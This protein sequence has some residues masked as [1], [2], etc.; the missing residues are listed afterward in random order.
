M[1]IKEYIKQEK[2]L[3]LEFD[4]RLNNLQA[5]FTGKERTKIRFPFKELHILKYI[6]KDHIENDFPD[7][8]L[9]EDYKCPQC[10]SPTSCRVGQTPTEFFDNEGAYGWLEVHQCRDCN[11]NYII[12]NGC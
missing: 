4:I 11:T 2:S 8:K 6:S 12:N 1:D 3:V 10:G 9:S 5:R 7:I